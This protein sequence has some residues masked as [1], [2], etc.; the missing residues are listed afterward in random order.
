MTNVSTTLAFATYDYKNANAYA[1]EQLKQLTDGKYKFSLI[2]YAY[3]LFTRL[4]HWIILSI[5][6]I[7]RLR[8]IW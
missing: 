2:Q 6:N 4:K 8:L 3:L 1:V 5:Y 7:R